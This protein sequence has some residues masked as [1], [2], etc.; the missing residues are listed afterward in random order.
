MHSNVKRRLSKPIILLI[1]FLC[2]CLTAAIGIG[3]HYVTRTV[4]T[5]WQ[6]IELVRYF[7]PDNLSLKLMALIDGKEHVDYPI[8]S[9]KEIQIDK[10]DENGKII[11]GFEIE[12]S[13]Y[14]ISG[15][16]LTKIYKNKD[17]QLCGKVVI[18][19]SLK[20]AEIFLYDAEENPI[21]KHILEFNENR[22]TAYDMN[23][24]ELY[25]YPLRVQ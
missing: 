10:I 9:G 2:I 6:N 18:A 16:R 22:V 24:I 19:E 17:G 15:D 1:A 5:H 4:Q 11:S 12:S 3:I 8:N 13:E 20:S 14:I 25:Q 23:G 7:A 21:E